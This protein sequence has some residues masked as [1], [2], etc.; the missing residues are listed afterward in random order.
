VSGC[1]HNAALYS[2]SPSRL[3]R[4]VSVGK[5]NAAGGTSHVLLGPGDV[6]GE[7]AF[8]TEVPQ[9]EVRRGWGAQGQRGCACSLPVDC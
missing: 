3:T 4:D 2:Q 6:V 5:H 8:F 9:L 1:R 7:V